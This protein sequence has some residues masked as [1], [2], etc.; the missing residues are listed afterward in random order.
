MDA[1]GEKTTGPNGSVLF[2]PSFALCGVVWVSVVRQQHSIFFRSVAE[3]EAT[4]RLARRWWM[5]KRVAK[6]TAVLKQCLVSRCQRIRVVVSRVP[7]YSP[8]GVGAKRWCVSSFVSHRFRNSQT[9]KSKIRGERPLRRPLPSRPVRSAKS[10][11]EVNVHYVAPYPPTGREVQNSQQHKESARS[12]PGRSII[13]SARSRV[14]I[15]RCCSSRTGFQNPGS[16]SDA[17]N[18]CSIVSVVSCRHRA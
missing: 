4:S 1:H 13:L 5:R 17:P 6:N 3:A 15:D 12:G 8:W 16:K 14:L 9:Q 11:E 2:I 18:Q 10:R 7:P